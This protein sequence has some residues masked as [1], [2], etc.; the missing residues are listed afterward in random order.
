MREGSEKRRK[1]GALEIRRRREGREGRKGRSLPTL[2]HAHLLVGKKK[3]REFRLGDFKVTHHEKGY[4][5]RP[6]PGDPPCGGL[7]VLARRK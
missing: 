4:V 2:S 5:K 3:R 7:A 1:S 6:Y